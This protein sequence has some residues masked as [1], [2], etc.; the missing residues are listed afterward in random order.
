MKAFRLWAS[1]LPPAPSS[2]TSLFLTLLLVRRE[3]HGFI[4]IK[5]KPRHTKACGIVFQTW[6]INHIWKYLPFARWGLT[7]PTSSF[8]LNRMF[9]PQGELPVPLHVPRL[10][11]P[12]WYSWC[13]FIG[14][15][16]LRRLW[17]WRFLLW[18]WWHGT[19][20]PAIFTTLHCSSMD[21]ITQ[22]FLGNFQVF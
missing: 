16:W 7:Y 4:L 10:S 14:R 20:I 21:L 15:W 1:C 8:H 11:V 19:V 5:Q 13:Y 18:R 6:R 17:W 22:Q 3:R 2:G 9:Y 12:V